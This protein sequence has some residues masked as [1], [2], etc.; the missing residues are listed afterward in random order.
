MKTGVRH[1]A[2][3]RWRQGVR[4]QRGLATELAGGGAGGMG[5]RGQSGRLLVVGNIP[6][7]CDP[8]IRSQEAVLGM[9]R[10]M[11][12]WNDFFWPQIVPDPNESLTVQ[13]ALSRPAGGYFLDCSLMLT[14]RLSA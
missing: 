6:I 12:A 14:A 9:V 10:F 4:E 1:G 5:R 11:A 13:V 7:H 2:P 3:S 8:A